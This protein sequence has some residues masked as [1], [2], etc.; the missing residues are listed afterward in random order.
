VSS[1]HLDTQQAD[2]VAAENTH[3]TGLSFDGNKLQWT[4]TDEALPLPLDLNNGMIQFVLSI[5]DL[6]E[7]DRQMLRIDN[8]PATRYIV[9]IDNHVITTFRHEELAAGVN[10]ALYSTPMLSQAREVDGD[11]L[12]R[13]QLDQANFILAIEDPKA[14][15]AAGAT[16]AIEEKDVVIED[17]QRKSA[18]PLPHTV[19]L[20]PE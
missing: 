4:Q 10:L 16:K 17:E 18:Q 6:A 13:T 19:E 3:I 9:K 15:D 5:S 20:D 14:P 7:M 8:L 1:V 2:P 12:K 11:E